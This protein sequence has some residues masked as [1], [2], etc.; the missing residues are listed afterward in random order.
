MKEGI[1][2]RIATHLIKIKGKIDKDIWTEEKLKTYVESKIDSEMQSLYHAD[3]EL[4]RVKDEIVNV[5]VFI[6]ALPSEVSKDII[7]KWLNNHIKEDGISVTSLD[8]EKR[9]DLTNQKETFVT[10]I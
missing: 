2:M 7:C 4:F 1:S 10:L 9:F 6:S 3:L 5:W 8:I